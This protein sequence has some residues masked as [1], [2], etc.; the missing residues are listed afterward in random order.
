MSNQSYSAT[1]TRAARVGRQMMSIAEAEMRLFSYHRESITTLPVEACG[2]F[3]R[4]AST[5]TQALPDFGPWAVAYHSTGGS[6]PTGSVTEAPS[7]EAHSFRHIPG[8]KARKL[9]VIRYSA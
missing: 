6:M 9:H 3:V 1:R 5:H 7:Y 8:I 4:I 2:H